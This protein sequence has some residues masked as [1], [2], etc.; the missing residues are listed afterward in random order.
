M[1]RPWIIAAA[2]VAVAAVGADLIVNATRRVAGSRDRAA[3]GTGYP[4]EAL[5]HRRV[6]HF[7]SVGGYRAIGALFIALVFLGTVYAAICLSED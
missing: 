3:R 5:S 2:L 1:L 7:E 6:P 4:F